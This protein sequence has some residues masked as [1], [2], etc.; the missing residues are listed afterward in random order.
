MTRRPDSQSRRTNH[1]LSLR[2]VGGTHGGRRLKYSG[3]P[4]VRPMKDRTREAVFNL[5]GPL[6]KP[7][8]AV[9]LFAGT[10]AMGLEAISRGATQATMIERHAPTARVIRD[11]VA[12]LEA[13]D[14]ANVVMADAFRWAREN[15]QS[16]TPPWLLFCCPPYRFYH[17]RWDDLK[18]MLDGLLDRAESQSIFVVEADLQF[19]PEQLPNADQWRVRDYAPARVCMLRL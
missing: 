7:I 16:A 9:D 5:L 8:H 1:P 3:D 12:T 4:Q 11:N 10:G 6:S 13:E 18:T 14:Q 15:P 19:E 17:E 2:I